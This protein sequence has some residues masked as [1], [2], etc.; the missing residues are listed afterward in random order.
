MDVAVA[1]HLRPGE[2]V[3]LGP[4]G[5]RKRPGVEAGRRDLSLIASTKALGRTVRIDNRDDI[6]GPGNNSYLY[7]DAD[8][9]ATVVAWDHNLAL[10]GG[11]KLGGR[12]RF[13]QRWRDDQDGTAW[14]V[15]PSA[16]LTVPLGD[17]QDPSLVLSEE[18]F[19]NL[20]TTPLQRKEGLERLRTTAFVTSKNIFDRLYWDAIYDNGVVYFTSTQGGVFVVG[21]VGDDDAARLD[22][23]LRAA[24]RRTRSPERRSPVRRAPAAST[25]RCPRRRPACR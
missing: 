7:F 23:R 19:F 22:D 17:K 21:N 6:D 24:A 11:A 2:Q 15:R 12:L 1:L 5:E 25:A 8:G 3:L 18:A 9:R 10:N 4:P 14:R 20:N 16:K 13:E